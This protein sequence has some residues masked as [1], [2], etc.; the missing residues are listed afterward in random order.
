MEVT[1]WRDQVVATAGA[2]RAG[3]ALS[4][5]CGEKLSLVYMP[6]SCFRRVDPDR[7]NAERRVGFADGFPLLVVNQSSLD[8]LNS[9]LEYPVDMRRFRPNIV[10]E[11]AGAWAEDLWREISVG[12]SQLDIVKPCSTRGQFSTSC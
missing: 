11:G 4:R 10:V 2:G 5:Y 9:R 8:E 1:V 3:E 6:D 12:D 7:V